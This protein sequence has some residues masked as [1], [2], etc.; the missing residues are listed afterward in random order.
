MHYQAKPHEEAKLV[1]CTMGA[2]YDV[3]VDICPDSPSFKQWISVELTA[4]NRKMLYIPGGM[5]HGFQTLV[6]NTEVFYQMSEFYHPDSAK[7][8]RWDDPDF[9][10]EWPMEPQAISSK[11]KAYELFSSDIETA[12]G[13]S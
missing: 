12:I 1:R 11:D 6:D 9:A 3:I 4:D 7:G 8:L 10:I 5:A 2:I 13:Q